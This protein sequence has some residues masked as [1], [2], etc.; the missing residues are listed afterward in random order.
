MAHYATCIK[1]A[2]HEVL[3]YV[4]L[5]LSLLAFE[6]CFEMAYLTTLASAPSCRFTNYWQPS[7]S[8]KT[9]T[10]ALRELSN[11]VGREGGKKIVVKLVYD[12]GTFQQ[13]CTNLSLVSISSTRER[14]CRVADFL[15]S[16]TAHQKPLS[17]TS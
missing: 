8:Q 9:I 3:L 11:R 2:K 7:D 4:S 16:F 6:L 17:R 13:V 1:N 15:A 14:S 12:R 5:P 10:D